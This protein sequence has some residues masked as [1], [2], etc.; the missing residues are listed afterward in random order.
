MH[1]FDATLSG[2]FAAEHLTNCLEWGAVS[3]R[4]PSTSPAMAKPVNKRLPM[5][6]DTAEAVAANALAFLAADAAR[7]SRLLSL[8]GL[9]A[10]ALRARA[11]TPELLC[12]V[13]E[14]L[15]GD[16]S[17]LLVFAGSVGVA[18]ETVTRALARLQDSRS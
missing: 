11:D 15:T 14:H 7:L 6:L 5:D 16:E 13:L 3:A 17:L 1:R 4:E 8:T 2:E 12:A 18:P 9:D 10:L